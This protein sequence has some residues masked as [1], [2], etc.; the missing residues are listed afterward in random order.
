VTNYDLE[1]R[2]CLATRLVSNPPFSSASYTAVGCPTYA[3]PTLAVAAL[4]DAEP[5]R[6][7]MG[8][9][10]ADVVGEEGVCDPGDG[11]AEL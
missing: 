4:R 1:V 9:R 6:A 5:L 2:D 3:P 7:A 8:Q 11:E 10:L